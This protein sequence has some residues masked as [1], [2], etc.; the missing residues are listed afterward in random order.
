MSGG[1]KQSVAVARAASWANK[2]IFLDEPTAA[3][4]VVQTHN[5]L[6]LIK[7]VRDKGIGVV[8]ISHSMPEV[9]S[10]ADR[11]QVLRRG[12]RVATLKAADSTL[13]QLVGAMTGALDEEVR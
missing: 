4:G 9:L 1:Q 3:L 7:R 12:R 8:F 11:V 10:V 6:E 13:E 5:V 2:I